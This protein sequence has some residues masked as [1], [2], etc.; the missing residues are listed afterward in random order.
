MV[1]IGKE[2]GGASLLL[3]HRDYEATVGEDK[4]LVGGDGAPEESCLGWELWSGVVK[5]SRQLRGLKLCD[6]YWHCA[7]CGYVKWRMEGCVDCGSAVEIVVEEEE[8]EE[9]C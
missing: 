4:G 6:R 9:Y 8:E 3:V 5:G 1:E 7:S 2:A